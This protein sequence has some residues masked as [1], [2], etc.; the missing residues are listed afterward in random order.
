MDIKA[1]VNYHLEGQFKVDIYNKEGQ[2]IESTDWFKNFITPTGLS[3]IYQYN[4]ADCFRFLSI[5]TDNASVQNSGNKNGGYGTT[6]LSSPISIITTS[7]NTGSNPDATG[8]SGV[9]YAADPFMGTISGTYIGQWGYAGQAQGITENP[10]G[11]IFLYRGWRI[12]YYDSVLTGYSTAPGSGLKINEFMV[13][14]S[15]GSDS[16]GNCAFSRV[17]KSVIIPDGTYAN[18]SYQLSIRCSSSNIQ[19]FGVGTFNTGKADTTNESNEL[20]VWSQLSGYYRQTYHGLCWIDSQGQTLIPGIGAIMEPSC[21]GLNEA[22]FYLSPDNSQ[23]DVSQTGGGQTNGEAAAYAADG[24]L[25]FCSTSAKFNGRASFNPNDVEGSPQY[26]VFYPT[27]K[28]G[29]SVTKLTSDVPINI[30]MVGQVPEMWNY[31]QQYKEDLSVAT[32]DS[33]TDASYATAG[34][35]SLGSGISTGDSSFGNQVIISTK[36]FNLPYAQGQTGLSRTL[37]RRHSF[38]PAQSLGPN[39]R[40]GS[41]VYAYINGGDISASSITLYP[42]MDCMFYDSSGQSTMSHYRLITGIYFTNRGSGILDAYTYTIP[43]LVNPFI[44]RTFQGPGTG[45][46]TSHPAIQGTN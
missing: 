34:V 45:D 29:N 2:L 5:G 13:S 9:A 8:W 24:L 7:L 44:H 6:G 12:P 16:A 33:Y 30:R 46:W 22:R 19:T 41:L 26:S 21:T 27:Q 14:P 40:F 25:K 15:S 39:T 32:P 31:T 37:T 4:F 23:F 3:Y 38:F 17:R 10:N 18:I 36:G 11:T 43:P 28:D 42:M 20:S 1:K 35:T